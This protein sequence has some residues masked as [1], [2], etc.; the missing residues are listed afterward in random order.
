MYNNNHA[1]AILP[2]F[3]AAR[4]IEASGP[5]SEQHLTKNFEGRC[6]STIVAVIPDPRAARSLRFYRFARTVD[7]Y[8]PSS[9]RLFNRGN[10][11]KNLSFLESRLTSAS[12][13]HRFVG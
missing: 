9:P 12:Y 3:V 8:H 11:V 6:A 2:T 13:R 5:R 1:M 4:A 10:T 7:G